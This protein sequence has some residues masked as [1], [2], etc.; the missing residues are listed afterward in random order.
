VDHKNNFASTSK[1]A[2]A[3][4]E[5]VGS[6]NVKVLYD[7]YHMQIME[8]NLISTIKNHY[9]LIGHYH[10]AGVPGRHEPLDTEVNYPSVFDAIA[11][12]GY[13]GYIGLEY[14]PSIDPEESL[15][16]VYAAFSHQFAEN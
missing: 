15:R 2:F 8:G 12:T 11:Q 16:R 1:E 7:V 4:V 13:D 3:I 6:A 10:I 5:T 9:D 14:G